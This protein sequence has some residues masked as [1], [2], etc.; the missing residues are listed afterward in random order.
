MAVTLVNTPGLRACAQGTGGQPAP[1]WATCIRRGLDARD[2]Q[3]VHEGETETRRR[4]RGQKGAGL[5]R[6]VRQ[7]AAPLL[8]SPPGQHGGLTPSTPPPPGA[9]AR[10][11][12]APQTAASQTGPCCTARPH[13]PRKPGRQPSAARAS[14]VSPARELGTRDSSPPSDP[15]ATDARAGSGAWGPAWHAER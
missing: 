7:R 10:S 13:R 11:R 12:A 15:D 4:D 9:R 8:A 14:E 1:L 3:P 5:L 2:N 6:F